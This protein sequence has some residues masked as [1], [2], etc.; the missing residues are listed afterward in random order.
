MIQ[1]I[2]SSAILSILHSILPNHWIPVLAVGMKE[3]W[4][5]WRITYV[6]LVAGLAHALSTIIIGFVIYLIG[7]QLEGQVEQL[8]PWIASSILV[9]LGIYFIWRHHRHDH[10]HLPKQSERTDLSNTRIIRLLV[11]AMFFSPCLEFAGLYL[12]ASNIGWTAVLIISLI[13]MFLS[14]TGMVLWVR[15]AYR[16]IQITNWHVLE[17]KLG[18]ISGGVLILTGILFIFIQ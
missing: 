7:I 4:Q 5:L 11:I 1:L 9:A 17:H 16:G 12:L 13:Y 15:L 6:T 14:V 2:T 18:L 3:Q 8:T 10:I